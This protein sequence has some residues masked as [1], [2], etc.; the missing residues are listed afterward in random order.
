MFIGR[1]DAKAE[2]PVLWLPHGKSWLMLGG[3]GGRKRR[4]WQTM[5]WVNGITDSMDVSLSELRELVMN[6]EAWRA[7]IHGVAKSWTWLS[8]WNELNWMLAYINHTNS[9]YRRER[10]SVSHLTQHRKWRV[11]K[12]PRTHTY[13]FTSLALITQ[14]FRETRWTEQTHLCYTCCHR[15]E[16]RWR[17]DSNT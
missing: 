4:G 11:I 1:T 3:V 13:T 15:P 2:T 14:I 5:R 17:R 12:F 10:I 9:S 7:L 6:R 8:D 16:K